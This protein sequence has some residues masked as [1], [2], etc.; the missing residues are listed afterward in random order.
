MKVKVLI[1]AI[2]FASISGSSIPHAQEEGDIVK[3][4]PD[5]QGPVEIP[6]AENL[7]NG[8]RHRPPATKRITDQFAPWGDHRSGSG[9]DDLRP[10]PEMTV[11]GGED[12]SGPRSPEGE[13]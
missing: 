13:D 5:Q 8:I 10:S 4:L 7:G 12:T 6:D 2:M 3:E 11:E 9:A 1:V